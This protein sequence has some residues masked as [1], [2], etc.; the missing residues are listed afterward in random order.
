[1]GDR[2]PPTSLPPDAAAHVAKL[3]PWLQEAAADAFQAITPSGSPAERQAA[4]ERAEAERTERHRVSAELAEEALA[5]KWGREV[6][7]AAE[8]LL[9]GRKPR[10]AEEAQLQTIEGL[11]RE[12][13]KRRRREAAEQVAQRGKGAR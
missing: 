7:A 2:K 13:Q 1:M 5:G 10:E 4:R 6:R 3:P 8:R 11:I 12:E 9:V